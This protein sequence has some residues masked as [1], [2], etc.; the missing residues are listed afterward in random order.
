MPFW[1]SG[2]TYHSAG[3]AIL[4]SENFKGKIQN[5]VND[6]T[7][8][9]ITVTFTLNKQNFHI[10]T[11]YGPNKPHHRENFFQSL[12]VHITSTQNTIIGGN[13]NMVTEFR[14][15]TGGT[16]CNT[17]LL[18]SIPLNEL[19]KNPNLQDTWRK[20]NP[21]KIN[22]T[23]HRTLSNIH[24]RLDRIYF[25]QN[26]NIIDSKIL[27]FEYPDHDALLAEFLLRVRTRGP[28]YW[29]L[30]TSILDHEA[31]CIAFQHF[32][33]KWKQQQKDYKNISTWWEVGKL[34]FKML[35]T[36]Y[37]VQMQ[38]N[39]RNKQDELTQ[40]ITIEK[41]KP[42]PNQ[43][44]IQ[45]A[46]QHLPDIGNYKI[47]GSIICSKEKIILDQEKPNKFFFD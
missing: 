29:K 39:I 28:G 36:Q 20:I 10:T 42:K 37:C 18:G 7:G 32:R 26:L 19:L 14:D 38:K 25:S 41:T 16:I 44:K 24:G 27:P 2:P 33:Q 34:Y 11:L 45:E 47:S 1:S 35:A 13:F 21:N 8:R 4:F 17:H 5:I 43:D 30:N 3:V 6:N 9:I 12:T 40:F 15:I 46:H 22:Y 23:Y 31:F